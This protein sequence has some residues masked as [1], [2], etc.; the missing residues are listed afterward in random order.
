MNNNLYSNIVYLLLSIEL[1]KKSGKKIYIYTDT[2]GQNVLKNFDLDVDIN[3]SVINK[4]SNLDHLRWSIPK[5]YT[6]KEQLEPFCHIDH[7]VFLW[8]G[9]YEQNGYELIVQNVEHGGFFSNM[10]KKAFERY[11]NNNSSIP[12]ELTSF[13]SNSFKDF[14]GFNCGYIDIYDINISQ[15]WANFAINL[16]DCFQNNFTW[17][18]CILIEQFS[19]YILNK[20]YNLSIGTILNL[21]EETSVVEIP[22]N[23]KYTHLM[24]AKYSPIILEKVENNIQKLNNN[25]YNKLMDNKQ[26]LTSNMGVI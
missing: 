8:Q 10:Y 4:L 22:E 17:N 19:L 16:N 15:K 21:N 14:G 26:F 7:D 3:T 2:L 5:L 25:L 24:K 11:I 23:I 13:L 9:L 18:D 1:S 6:I 12:D 20:I